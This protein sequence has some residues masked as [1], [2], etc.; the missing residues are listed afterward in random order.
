MR[1]STLVATA[2]LFASCALP[3]A[4]AP[5]EVERDVPFDA[6]IGETVRV[7]GTDARVTVNGI[8]DSRCPSDVTCITAGDAVVVLRT[9]ERVDTL[10]TARA[11]RSVIASGLRLELVDVKPYPRSTDRDRVSLAVLRISTER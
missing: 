5:R 7:A 3:H 6:A 10:H 2:L 8:A 1:A 9:G 11:P 4:V